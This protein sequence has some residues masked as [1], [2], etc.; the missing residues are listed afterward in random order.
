MGEG[1]IDQREVR[2]KSPQQRKGIKLTSA[3]RLEQQQPRQ[4]T[5]QGEGEVKAE[6]E[7]HKDLLYRAPT[8]IYEEREEWKKKNNRSTV[9]SSSPKGA[10][11]NSL[12][13]HK[14]KLI[15]SYWLGSAKK[16][17]KTFFS[18][19]LCDVFIS[20][21][22]K[23]EKNRQENYRKAL[24]KQQVVVLRQAFHFIFLP[25]FRTHTHQPAAAAAPIYT[26]HKLHQFCNFLDV[27]S[28]FFLATSLSLSLCSE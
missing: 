7:E 22:I 28:L 6:V 10:A 23:S 21:K 5:R 11:I 3:E 8:H 2:L 25:S 20:Q 26:L 17:K 12:G 14:K 24:D 15:Q 18:L 1:R 4:E 13:V 9:A 19:R 16:K 27:S